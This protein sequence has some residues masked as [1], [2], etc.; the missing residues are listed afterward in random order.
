V[1]YEVRNDEMIKNREYR[2]GGGI[3]AIA[4]EKIFSTE[5]QNC[6]QK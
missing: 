4:D 3:T 6:L 1:Q 5:E 2:H